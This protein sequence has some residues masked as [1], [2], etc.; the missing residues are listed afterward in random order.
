MRKK[1]VAACFCF[2]ILGVFNG[3]NVLNTHA[4]E[5]AASFSNSVEKKQV[6]GVPNGGWSTITVK[7]TYSEEYSP[8]GNGASISLNKRQKIV[9]WQRAYATS[10]PTVQLLNIKHSNGTTF[11]SFSTISIMY[12]APWQ[13]ANGGQN[14]QAVTVRRSD[15][16]TG[17]LPFI[18]AC[19]GGVPASATGSVS[20]SFK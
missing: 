17:N 10:C 2:A 6:F 11:S 9:M 16:I 13:G 5:R 14:T 19:S 12:G 8:V 3:R 18:L 1:I 7:V 4:E 15:G 20:L